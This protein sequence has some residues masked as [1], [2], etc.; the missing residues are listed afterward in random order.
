MLFRSLGLLWWLRPLYAPP[1]PTQPVSISPQDFITWTYHSATNDAV[2]QELTVY[3]DGRS[4]LRLTRVMGD[5]DT[6]ERLFD[7]KI[8]RDKATGLTEFT[9]ET[10]L[11]VTDAKSLLIHALSA[12]VLD[13]R[14]LP[15]PPAEWL[16]VRTSFAGSER[17][18]TGPQNLS[19]AFDWNPSVWITRIWWQKTA[20]VIANHRVGKL[21]EKK[22]FVL[23]DDN[24]TPLTPN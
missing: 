17:R 22:D 20:Q 19:A 21:L 3:G 10:A 24:G 16:E 15:T 4:R 12:G 6:P 23:V 11:S 5:P 9:R 18:S 2:V 8:R 7:Y 13:V 1:K 14:D